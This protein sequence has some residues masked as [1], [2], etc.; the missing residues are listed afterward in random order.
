MTEKDIYTVCASSNLLE[1]NNCW[2]SVKALSQ[3]E[4]KPFGDIASPLFNEDEKGIL[5]V[6]F[7]EDLVPNEDVDID[8]L[9]EL[10]SSF[11]EQIKRKV[12]STNK[13][14]IVCWGRENNQHVIEL[15]S[16]ENNRTKFHIWIT[17]Q[18]KDLRDEFGHFLLVTLDDIFFQFGAKN[19]FSDRN[20]YFARCR[21]SVQGLKVLTDAVSA[22]MNRLINA[23][24]KVLVLDCDNTIWGG[25]IGEDGIS[26]L[27]LGQDGLGTAFVDFQKEVV[28]LVNEGVILVLASKNDEQDVWDVFDNHTEMLL[29]SEHVVAASINWYE[30]AINVKQIAQDLDL[31]LN[32]FVFWDDNPLE[33]D[34]MKALNHQVLT[35][36]VPKSVLDWPKLLRSNEYFSKFKTT[37]EDRKKVGQYKSRAKFTNDI[38]NASDITSYLST[39]NLCP[40]ASRLDETNVARAEQLCMKTNQ[41]TIRSKRHSASVLSS[42]QQENDDAVFLVRLIDNYGDHGLVSLVCLRFLNEDTVFLDTF[43]M[44]CRVLGRHLE[45]WI[46][47]ETVR[48]VKKNGAKYLFTEFVETKRNSIAHDFLHAYGFKKT[49]GD[50]PELKKYISDCSKPNTITYHLDTTDISIPNL[51]IYNGGK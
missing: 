13:P 19:M 12:A 18:L 15:A 8:T 14:F 11:L 51:E 26:G 21:L 41:F 44:S 37:D 47:D 1:T 50:S 22:L 40:V 6:L 4:F 30:K 9:K 49:D 31:N 29:K 3:L 45:A 35:V 25:V 20:W 2:D 10:H 34:K 24:S 33:R 38:K 48:R 27:V 23:P 5:M 32:S 39:L 16:S 7:L 28:K 42:Y 36:D 43:L 17:N 46:L